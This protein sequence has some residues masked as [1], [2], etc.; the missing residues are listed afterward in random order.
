MHRE[1][2][3]SGLLGQSRARVLSDRASDHQQFGTEYCDGD[4]A[5]EY[6]LDTLVFTAAK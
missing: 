5:A 1:E 3:Y 6:I 2:K 4:R